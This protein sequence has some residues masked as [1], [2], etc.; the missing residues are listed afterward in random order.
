MKLVNRK[1]SMLVLL[2]IGFLITACNAGAEEDAAA[3]EPESA[4]QTE[5]PASAEILLSET[6]TFPGFGFSIDY[7]AG[8]SAESRDTVTVIDELESDLSTAF[9]DNG[10]PNQGAGISL[11]QRTMAY[12]T[13]IGLAEEPTLEDLFDLNKGFF[14]WQE[15]VEPEEAEAF[16]EPALAVRTSSSDTWSYT[17]M[18]YANDRAFLLHFSAPTE[19]ELDELMPT[20]EQILASI[21][22][23]EE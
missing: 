4:Q 8:W 18:G 16:G 11:D 15:S 1:I 14:E 21:Q 13:G 22:P 17:V 6:H 20:W 23:V 9:Q 10:P 5:S 3:Q 19:K 2:T 12:M 7:P